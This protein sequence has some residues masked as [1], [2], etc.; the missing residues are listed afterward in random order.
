[1][2]VERVLAVL[3]VTACFH[4]RLMFD[5]EGRCFFWAPP[6]PPPPPP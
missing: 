6:P 2:G 4:I 5:Y 1:M 3:G